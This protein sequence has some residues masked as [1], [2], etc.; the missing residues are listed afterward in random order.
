[1]YVYVPTAIKSYTM[2]YLNLAIPYT[3]LDYPI[4]S[5]APEINTDIEYNTSNLDY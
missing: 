2:D 1:V 3:K 5:K 4:V